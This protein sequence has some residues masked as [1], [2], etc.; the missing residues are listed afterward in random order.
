MKTREEIESKLHANIMGAQ[1]QETVISFELGV[2]RE[3][4]LDIRDLL[5]NPPKE[6]NG[7]GPIL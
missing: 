2:I 6:I 7:S 3:A 1:L 5:A 4:I